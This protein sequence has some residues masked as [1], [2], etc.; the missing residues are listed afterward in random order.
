MG[1]GPAGGG[2]GGDVNFRKGLKASAFQ[3]RV[4]SQGRVKRAYKKLVSGHKMETV[5]EWTTDPNECIC[6]GGK[7][8]E[9]MVAK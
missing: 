5:K 2:G 9:V 4:Q 8:T 6:Q 1:R 3:G 7:G